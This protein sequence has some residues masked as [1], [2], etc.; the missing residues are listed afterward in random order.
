MAARAP[1]QGTI[2]DAPS[3]PANQ[4]CALWIE[5]FPPNITA[6]EILRRIVGV[7]KIYKLSI[8]KP[9]PEDRHRTCGLKLVFWKEDDVE[10]FL[11]LYIRRQFFFPGF[12]LEI[13]ENRHQV[14]RQIECDN[15]RVLHITGPSELVNYATLLRILKDNLYFETDEVITHSPADSNYGW[16]EWRFSSYLGEASNARRV[17]D[18]ALEGKYIAG[19]RGSEAQQLR[20]VVTFWGA[21][22]CERDYEASRQ[23]VEN[24]MAASAAWLFH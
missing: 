13:N 10:R 22:P 23:R 8:S 2:P 11:T 20:H 5:G 14:A 1:Y 7:G 17:L 9:K 16:L 6:H 4:N 18:R 3:M 21:D 15:S 12:V 24:T 19:L